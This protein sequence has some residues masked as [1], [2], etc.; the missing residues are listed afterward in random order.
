VLL[1]NAETDSY[2]IF[3]YIV[4]LRTKAMEFFFIIQICNSATS[5]VPNSDYTAHGSYNFQIDD[6]AQDIS[7]SEVGGINYV[8]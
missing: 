6:T 7:V 4:R 2:I 5:F 1:T 8:T 3:C